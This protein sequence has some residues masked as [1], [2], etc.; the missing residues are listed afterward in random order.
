[1]TNLAST[2][3]TGALMAGV[4]ALS[5]LHLVA[6]PTAQAKAR[7]TAPTT[8]DIGISEFFMLDCDQFDPWREV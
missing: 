2:I 3:L 4:I 8:C 1:M 7:S 6:A 5:A